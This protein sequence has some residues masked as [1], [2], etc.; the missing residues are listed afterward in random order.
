MT[1]QKI[2]IEICMGSSC[3]SRGNSDNLQAIKDFLEK[4]N[5]DDK[6][7]LR[8]SLCQGECKYG[9]NIVINGKRYN[10]VDRGSVI[11]IL[12]NYLEKENLL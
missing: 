8:G 9:P 7:D 11:D 1:K 3:F 5:L 2:Q 12:R 10:E 6:V 4:H